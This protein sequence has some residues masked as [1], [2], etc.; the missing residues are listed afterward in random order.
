MIQTYNQ[1]PIEIVKGSGNFVWDNH[2]KKYLD[3]YGGHATC[4]LGHCPKNVLNAINQQSRDLLFYSNI[5]YTKPQVRLAKKLA[6]TLLPQKYQVYFV[7]SGSEANEAAIKMAR[8]YTGK[9]H[10]ISFKNSFHGR[11]IT[12]LS[13]TG[14]PSYHQFSPNL[15]SYTTFAELGDIESV[16]K[17]F[18]QDTACVICE[19]IQSIGGMKMASK[20]FY[21]EL[22]KLC[23]KKKGLLVFDEV[24]TGLG[25][26]GAFWFSKS[27]GIFPDIITTAKGL[28]SGLPLAA[29]MVKHTVSATIQSGE[30]ATTFGGGPVVCTAALAT[31]HTIL[32][33][34]FLHNVKMKSE[35]FRSQLL[36]FNSVKAISGKGFLLGVTL[37]KPIPHLVERCLYLGLIIGSSFD[38]ATLRLM[39]PLTVSKKDIDLFLE[40]FSSVLT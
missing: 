8:K 22:E 39:P 5:F 29:V 27:M 32:E 18:T 37:K 3:F 17:S 11:S 6:Q 21:K 10:I 12:S 26:T 24:Q 38:P 4:L 2:G 33:K 40:I 20:K 34:E 1:Y 19:P 16:E 30:H 25:R 35:Y 7:N 23:K 14:I 13:V 28:A 9:Q 15:D 31:I 36:N